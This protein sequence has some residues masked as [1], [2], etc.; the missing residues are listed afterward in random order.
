M[1]SARHRVII[2]LSVQI[3]LT[4]ARNSPGPPQEELFITQNEILDTFFHS[5]RNWNE[6][7]LKIF[8]KKCSRNEIFI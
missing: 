3:Y 4:E 7:F 6:I 8:G 2:A 1:P 5:F